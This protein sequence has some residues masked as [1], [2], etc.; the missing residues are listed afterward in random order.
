LLQF[1]FNT[2]NAKFYVVLFNQYANFH[3]K[4]YEHKLI[5]NFLAIH[6]L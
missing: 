6:N 1:K 3:N 4:P 2:I 5:F